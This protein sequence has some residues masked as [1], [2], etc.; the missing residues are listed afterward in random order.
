MAVHKRTI[1]K[2]FRNTN[3]SAHSL[4]IRLGSRQRMKCKSSHLIAPSCMRQRK[5]HHVASV[6]GSRSGKKHYVHLAARQPCQNEPRRGGLQPQKDM[7]NMRKALKPRL[8]IFFL[9]P[10]VSTACLSD[11]TKMGLGDFVFGAGHDFHKG[12]KFARLLHGTTLQPLQMRRTNYSYSR[13]CL[14]CKTARLQRQA[15][16]RSCG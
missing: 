16:G 15:A 14:P 12:P 5:R 7:D 11:S 8:E 3:Q 9:A 4:Q 1:L 6:T 13:R 2:R 10:F